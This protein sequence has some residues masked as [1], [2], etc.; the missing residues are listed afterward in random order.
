MRVLLQLAGSSSRSITARLARCLMVKLMLAC[1]AIAWCPWTNLIASSTLPSI[2]T[3]GPGEEVT[4][5]IFIDLVDPERPAAR[6]TLQVPTARPGIHMETLV[7]SPL[8][9]PRA[10]LAV[11]DN[12]WCSIWMQPTEGPVYG[13]RAVNTWRLVHS[14]QQERALVVKWLAGPSPYRWSESPVA[15]GEPETLVYE[16]RFLAKDPRTSTRWPRGGLL[17]VLTVLASGLV[18]LTW[19][20]FPA[21]A[22]GASA[23]GASYPTSLGS[24]TAGLLAADGAVT[25]GGLLMVAVVPA[26]QPATVVTFEVAPS[27]EPLGGS[28]GSPLQQGP[29]A[30]D[31]RGIGVGGLLSASVYPGV[32]PVAAHLLMGSSSFQPGR[33]SMLGGSPAAAAGMERAR[34]KGPPM[35]V[36]MPVSHLNAFAGGCAE[37]RIVAVAMDPT[38]PGTALVTL[39]AEGGLSHASSS[40]TAKGPSS[41]GTG[42]GPA[43]SNRWRVQRW[44]TSRRA[45]SIHR[46]FEAGTPVALPQASVWTCTASRTMEAHCSPSEGGTVDLVRM[47]GWLGFSSLGVELAVSLLACGAHVLTGQGLEHLGRLGLDDGGGNAGSPQLA[48]APNGACLAATWR[49]GSGS[50]AEAESTLRIW[51]T[52]CRLEA[53]GATSIGSGKARA[54]LLEQHLVDRVWWSLVTGTQWWDIV[55][56]I[57]SF[58]D[59]N[60]VSLTLVLAIL[61]ASFHALPTL[62][63]RLH[64]APLLDSVKCK[65]LEAA[66]AADVQAVMLDMQARLLLSQ[67]FR[68]V[69]ASLT[70][71]A[72]LLERPWQ[73]SQEQQQQ[74]GSDAM[75]TDPAATPIMHAYVDVILDLTLYLLIRLRRSATFCK[76]IARMQ[77][78]SKSAAAGGASAASEGSQSSS[79]RAATALGGPAVPER[80]TSSGTATL[81]SLGGDVGSAAGSAGQQPPV[82]SVKASTFPQVPGVRLVGDRHFLQRLCQV[83]LFSLVFVRRNP[84]PHPQAK[85]AGVGNKVEEVSGRTL[86][87]GAGNGGQGYTPEEIKVLFLVV[88]DLNKRT[89]GL[90]TLPLPPQ[91]MADDETAIGLHYCDGQVNVPPELIE[92]TIGPHQHKLPRPTGPEAAGLLMLELELQPP[93]DS[94]LASLL[95]DGDS[96]ESH[97]PAD[98]GW[99][100][101][102]TW[103]RKRRYAERDA[104]LGIARPDEGRGLQFLDYL[105]SRRDVVASTWRRVPHETWYMCMQ[106]GRQTASLAVASTE[107]G[108][109]A[110]EAMLRLKWWAARFAS[111][112]PMCG[113]HWM[114]LR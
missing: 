47:P 14:W 89:S 112:C 10:L 23:W 24:G 73:A 43:A 99:P 1:S 93:G 61:D 103:P 111:S 38:R 45:S 25:S 22:G 68:G 83:L 62:Q 92:A 87:L 100:D 79:E 71:N 95:H 51:R 81:A 80:S 34:R 65:V 105:G 29:L 98:A 59:G 74:L 114:A 48:F 17:C 7:W 40:A 107:P 20:Q 110:T 4:F 9:C 27:I 69:E 102:L 94:A 39:L 31:P 50:E 18:G 72:S 21:P 49:A 57:L 8:G 91:P 44:E 53:T 58:S 97:T 52:P 108:A 90:P 55:A 35:F 60:A 70:N 56:A 12:A 32:S 6:T 85:A 26:G 66:E 106:C 67:A 77:Q 5:S 42:D 75:V 2:C 30:C 13:A 54:S 28:G 96:T 37:Q 36:C 64:Y 88:M 101:V 19:Q 41:G 104:A 113:G 16:E 46:F 109:K 63:H 76:N 33:T 78:V 15:N 3:S 11:D 86:R 84:P 82:L